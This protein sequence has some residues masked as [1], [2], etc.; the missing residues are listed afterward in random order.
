MHLGRGTIP[1]AFIFSGI[2]GVGKKKTAIQFAMACNCSSRDI[3]PENVQATAFVTRNTDIRRVG[4]CGRCRSCR[5]ISTGNHPDIVHLEP[6]GN[7]IRISQIRLLIHT[8]ALKPYEADY[9][10]VLLTDAHL[11]NPEAGNALLK[12]LEEPPPRTI[13]ILTVLQAS[14]LLPTIVSRCQ[15]IRFNPLSRKDLTGLLVANRKIEPEL[16]EIISIMARGSYTKALDMIGT[17]WPERRRWLL[18]ASGLDRLHMEKSGSIRHLLAFAEKLLQSRESVMDSLEIM[19]TWLRDLMIYPF[20][21]EKIINQ[22]LAAT[23]QSAAGNAGY[24]MLSAK[25]EAIQSAQKQ[26]LANANVKLTLETMMLKLA[27][28]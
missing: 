22:D 26:I 1:H 17:D 6:S 28:A 13:L 2:A 21:P 9:R 16:A 20:S 4:P 10:V 12:M 14:D 5:K 25:I 23:I 8:L 24:D 11:M 18:T 3:H 7:H 19:K 27:A 15:H